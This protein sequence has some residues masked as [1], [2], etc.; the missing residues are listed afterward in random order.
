MVGKGG[1]PGAPIAGCGP[2]R[3]CT[4]CLKGPPPVRGAN[5]PLSG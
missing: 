2:G 3:L 4:G 5:L 1:A